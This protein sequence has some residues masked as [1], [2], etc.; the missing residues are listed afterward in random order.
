MAEEI[1]ARDL[2]GRVGRAAVEAFVSSGIIVHDGTG[3]IGSVGSV[4]SMG[5]VGGM[6]G[7]RRRNNNV[8][9]GMTCMRNRTEDRRDGQRKRQQARKGPDVA[10]V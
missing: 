7:R 2:H 1:A 3:L 9:A 8:A 10:A 5:K 6:V 4:G